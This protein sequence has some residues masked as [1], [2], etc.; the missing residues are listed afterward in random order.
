LT[1]VTAIMAGMASGRPTY[2]L[3][4][5]AYGDT[6]AAGVEPSAGVNFV[7][8][9]DGTILVNGDNSGALDNYNWITPT[10]GSTAHYVRAT[11]ISGTF[12]TGATGTWLALTSNRSWVVRVFIAESRSTT[13]TF[14]IATDSGGT[15]IVASGLV[16]INVELF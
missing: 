14:E 6:G 13:A 2:R 3:D 16:T 11:L 9:S 4:D 5:E 12:N 8:N 10:T 15:N 1:G 7:V